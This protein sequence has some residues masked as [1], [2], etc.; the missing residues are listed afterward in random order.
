MDKLIKNAETI[1]LSADNI[2]EINKNNS[3]IIVYHNLSQYHNFKSMFG[4]KECVILLYETKQNFGHWVCI[5]E[6][7]SYYEF[8]DSYGFQPDEELNYARYDN[9]AYLTELMKTADKPIRT[10]KKRLQTFADEVNTCGRWVATRTRLNNI[11]LPQFNS[12]FT[13]NSNPPDFYVS[14][15]TYLYTI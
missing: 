13:G 7:P 14:M 1:D 9:V 10:N 12:L 15:L 3:N 5:L 11:E 2:D 4:N 6:F 8:F